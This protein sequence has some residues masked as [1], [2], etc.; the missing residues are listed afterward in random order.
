MIECKTNDWS[1]IG[2]IL[3][4][5][6]ARCP[7]EY[8]DKMDEKIHIIQECIDDD[9]LFYRV[10]KFGVKPHKIVF[11]PIKFRGCLYGY[12]V[13]LAGSRLRMQKIKESEVK[14]N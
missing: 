5:E 7:L 3:I 14:Y 1:R 9:A 4:E 13:T 10:W 11:E 8:Q 12:I 6:A 2:D